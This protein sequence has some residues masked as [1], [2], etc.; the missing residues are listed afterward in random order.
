[1]QRK[2]YKS[3][4]RPL[5]IFGLKGN[6]IRIFGLVVGVALMA[7]LVVGVVTGSGPGMG[8]FIV[9]LVGGFFVCLV[10]QARMPSR[11]LPKARLRSRMEFRVIRRRTL[12][13]IV[14]DNNQQYLNKT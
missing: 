4:D 2:Y 10:L 13:K 8:V 1:M 7:A 14:A 3:L 12:A 6:W 9:G 11:R 5:N